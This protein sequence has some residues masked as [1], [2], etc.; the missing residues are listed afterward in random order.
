MDVRRAALATQSQALTLEA[1]RQQSIS[2]LGTLTARD[3]EA[4]S[5]AQLAAQTLA[6]AEKQL[7]AEQERFRTGGSTALQVRTAEDDV[8]SARL[9][10]LRALV[11]LVQIGASV[12]YVTGQALQARGVTV[13]PEAFST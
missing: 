2:D 10:R 13:G 7:S 8:R 5:R 6:I 12:E 11:D 9:R 3:A 1:T 4:R